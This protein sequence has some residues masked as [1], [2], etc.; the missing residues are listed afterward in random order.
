MVIFGPF[1]DFYFTGMMG[2]AC[3]ELSLPANSLVF[4]TGWGSLGTYLP[5]DPQFAATDR[6]SHLDPVPRLGSGTGEHTG[7]H[8]GDTYRLTG[9]LGYHCT[10]AVQHAF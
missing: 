6:I 7:E 1:C 10:V 8:T 9:T 3:V 2:F 5:L 4:L